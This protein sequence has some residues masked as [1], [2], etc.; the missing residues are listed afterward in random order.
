LMFRFAKWYF[1]FV[2]NTTTVGAL[3]ALGRKTQ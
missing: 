1:D 3:L 2:K